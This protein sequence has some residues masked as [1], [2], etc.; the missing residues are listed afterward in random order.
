EPLSPWEELPDVYSIWNCQG[1]SRG[2]RKN[3][4]SLEVPLN[5]AGPSA[6]CD[7]AGHS[8]KIDEHTLPDQVSTLCSSVANIPVCK[9]HWSLLNMRVCWDTRSPFPLI[10]F[11]FVQHS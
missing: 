1:Y 10:P 3:M 2:V 9:R 8:F 11:G 7:P 5:R 4:W 6:Y